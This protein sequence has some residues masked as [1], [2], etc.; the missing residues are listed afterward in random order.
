[1]DPATFLPKATGTFDVED[2]AYKSA[3]SF[4]NFLTAHV[5]FYMATLPDDVDSAL[6]DHITDGDAPTWLEDELEDGG[7]INE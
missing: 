4:N 6:E 2:G 3:E 1:M 7:L 5:D